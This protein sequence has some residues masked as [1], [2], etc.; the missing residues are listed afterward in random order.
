MCKGLARCICNP[1]VAANHDHPLSWGWGGGV[2]V[3][4]DNIEVFFVSSENVK[5]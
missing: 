3:H 2:L 5:R 1:T 4:E